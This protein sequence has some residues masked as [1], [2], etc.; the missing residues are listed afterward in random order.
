MTSRERVARTL[1]R[2][3]PDRVPIYDKFWFEAEREWREQLGCPYVF[4]PERSKFDWG[5]TS[6]ESQTTTLWDIFDMDIT[7]VAWPDY[8]LRLVEPQI[9]EETDEWIRQRDGNEAVLRW[10]KHKMGTPEHVSYGIDTPEKWAKVKHLLTASRERLR[11]DEF[12]P[13]YGRARAADRFLC[14]S[15]VEPF[16]MAKDVLGHEIMLKAMIKQPEWIHDIFDTYTRVAIE[17]FELTEAEGMV[18]DGAFVYG[19][20][21]YNTG[22]FMSPRHFREFLMPYHKRM[23]DEFHNRD[24]PVIFHSDGDIR[25]VL[26]DLIDAGVD[27]INPL[28]AKANMDVRELAPQYGNRLGF[29]GNIDVRVLLTN[30]PERIRPEVRSKLAAAMPYHGYICHSDHSV[31]PGVKLESY[32]LLL[33]EVKTVGRYE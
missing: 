28:E 6:P 32:K 33:E 4:G 16:E 2:Q 3:Q 9:L 27:A 24:M 1:A 30:D 10:W 21:A 12:W 31:P 26:D 23:F 7:E 5:A 19:D 29:V 22:P 8:R 17:M 25:L 18:C 13:Q 15:T 14:Y 20:M 11:L